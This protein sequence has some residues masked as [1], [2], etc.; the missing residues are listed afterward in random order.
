MLGSC[1]F[2]CLDNLVNSLK[3]ELQS[4][5]KYMLFCMVLYRERFIVCSF[6]SQ[7]LF[8]KDSNICKRER[9]RGFLV[10]ASIDFVCCKFK[11]KIIFNF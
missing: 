6:Q 7:D 11:K 10:Q 1:Q 5:N 3:F 2:C 4:S 8:S 9:E